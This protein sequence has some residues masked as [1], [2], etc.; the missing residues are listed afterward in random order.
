MGLAGSHPAIVF[1]EQQ[2]EGLQAMWNGDAHQYEVNPKNLETPGLPQ[3]VAL[4]GRFMEQHY[5]RCF[6][7]D[8]KAPR[9]GMFWNQFRIG[10]VDYLIRSVPEFSQVN[11]F[12]SEYLLFRC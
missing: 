1:K 3:Y 6:G 2:H 7:D 4:M 9:D 12:G 5:E 11:S 8:T 10:V